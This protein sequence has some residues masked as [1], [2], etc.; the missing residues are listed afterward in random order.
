MLREVEK[1][2]KSRYLRSG[3]LAKLTGVSTD[4]LRH[5]ERIGVLPR[6]GRTAAGYRRYP[7]H[8]VDRVRLVRAALA[9]G[10]SLEELAGVLRVRDRGGAPCR[11]VHALAAE[12]LAQLD[13]KIIE[14]TQSD[15]SC[16]QLSGSGTSGWRGLLKDSER[17][18]LKH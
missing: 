17:G 4:T 2:D 10:F 7:A 11:Q 15:R 13:L 18:C 1:E 3:E 5:Y 8:A 14:L 6:P 16:K 9:L 12:K